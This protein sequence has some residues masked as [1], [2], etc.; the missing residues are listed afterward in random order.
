MADT[1]IVEGFDELLELLRVQFSG[2][3]PKAYLREK[4]EAAFDEHEPSDL[5]A[6][7]FYQRA[8]ERVFRELDL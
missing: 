8:V 1:V 2:T 4:L 3:P 5:K 6:R 7:A